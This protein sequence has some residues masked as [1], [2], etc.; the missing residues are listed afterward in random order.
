MKL[1]ASA[2]KQIQGEK[3][4]KR[5]KTMRMGRKGHHMGQDLQ[6]LIEEGQV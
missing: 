4:L 5:V 1:A 3:G 6:T 2:A